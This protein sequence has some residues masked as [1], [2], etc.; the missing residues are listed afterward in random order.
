MFP[1]CSNLKKDI[2]VCISFHNCLIFFLLYD[3]YIKLK[4]WCPSFLWK[5]AFELLVLRDFTF[6]S[7]FRCTS[8]KMAANHWS[9]AT[10]DWP[11]LSTAPYTQS[12]APQHMWLQKSLQRLGKCFLCVYWSAVL[13]KELVG[14]KN[15]RNNTALSHPNRISYQISFTLFFFS[16]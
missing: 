1:V 12:V 6:Y 10:L 11:P 13:A 7:Y 16:L 5:R 2:L 4:P 15:G 3:E 9:W 14:F 8:T